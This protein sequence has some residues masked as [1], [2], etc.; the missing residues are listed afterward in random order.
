LVEYYKNLGK[1]GCRRILSVSMDMWQ[2]Y[3]G[4]TREYVPN[5]DSIICF[6]KFHV[7]QYLGDAVDKVRRKE[8]KELLQN[9]DETLKGSRYYW[10]QNPIN[11]DSKTEQEFEAIRD[12]S[13]RTAKAWAIKEHAMCLWNYTYRA[14]AT[15]H[16]TFWYN[17]ACS[18]DLEPVHKAA[19][20]IKNNLWGIVNAIAL[21]R[22]NAAAESMNSRIQRLKSR[23]RGFRVEHVSKLSSSSTVLIL[24]CIRRFIHIFIPHE[25]G[26]TPFCRR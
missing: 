14:V 2:G 21:K 25:L 15:K 3:I 16:W 5:A 23:A 24:S 4:A 9:G 20:T 6:D 1:A 11:M 8:N 10:L 12:S 19:E 26:K 13:L 22:T 7:A 18:T 17:W